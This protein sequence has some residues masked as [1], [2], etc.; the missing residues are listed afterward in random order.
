MSYDIAQKAR[1][2]QASYQ[3]ALARLNAARSAYEQGAGGAYAAAKAR[4]ALIERKIEE[5]TEEADSASAA[6]RQ[7]FAAGNFE[8]TAVVREALA[9]KHE[10]EGM[11][12]ALRVALGESVREM[13]HHLLDASKQGREYHAAH[14]SAYIAYV[15]AEAYTALAQCGEAI[16]RAMALSRAIPAP[17]GYYESDTGRPL[18]LVSGALQRHAVQERQAYI[19]AALTQMAD[20]HTEHVRVAEIGSFDLGA[21]Q[22]RELLSPVQAAQV[23]RGMGVEG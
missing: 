17:G 5:A 16:A 2:A 7:A 6:Y 10:A 3:A 23:R 18:S 14:G 8:K 20:Q 11:V 19:H 1:E 9:R 4:R 21:L 22:S 15:H 13:Q 12:D